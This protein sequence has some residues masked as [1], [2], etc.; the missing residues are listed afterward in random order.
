MATLIDVR[1]PAEPALHFYRATPAARFPG[2]LEAV[3]DRS[4]YLY[5]VLMLCLRG[6]WDRELRQFMPA[7]SLRESVEALISLGLIESVQA[8]LPAAAAREE[9][10]RCAVRPAAPRI[11]R[12]GAL[13]AA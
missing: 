8:P 13:V 11:A 3:H 7:E 5:D 9:P 2:M 12:A 4:L 10:R 1:I 6:A